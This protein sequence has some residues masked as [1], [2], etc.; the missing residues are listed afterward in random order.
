[1][2]DGSRIAGLTSVL[3]IERQATPASDEEEASHVRTSR[4]FIAVLAKPRRQQAEQQRK[5]EAQ[6]ERLDR[7]SR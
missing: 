6:S 4:V 3:W 5:A 2:I 1:M 7:P